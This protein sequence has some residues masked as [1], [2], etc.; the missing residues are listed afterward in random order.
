M[1]LIPHEINEDRYSFIGGWYIDSSLCDE[2]IDCHNQLEGMNNTYVAPHPQNYI[3][4]ELLTYP[5]EIVDQYLNTLYNCHKEYIELYPACAKTSIGEYGLINGINVQHYLPNNYYNA[6][7]T[8]RTNTSN[9]KDRNFVFMTYLNDIT[10]G[11][12]TLF[13]HQNLSFKPVKGLTLIWPAEWTHLHT[14]SRTDEHKYIVTGWWAFL[15][16]LHINLENFKNID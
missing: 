6:W 15:S 9:Y 2:I 14:G 5:K 11:G 3:L 13:F 1:N 8:E 10:L 12:E 7:H 4:T 16:Q